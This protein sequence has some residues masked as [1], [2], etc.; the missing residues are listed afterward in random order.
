MSEE[1]EVSAEKV[2]TKADVVSELSDVEVHAMELGWKPKSEFK[3]DNKEFVSADEYL[4]RGPLIKEIMS[5]NKEIRE[6]K[7]TLK[8]LSDHM[9]NAEQAAYQRGMQAL[10]QK[11]EEAILSGDVE[12]VKALDKQKSDMRDQLNNGSPQD[13][14]TKEEKDF[15]DKHSTWFNDKPENREITEAAVFFDQYLLKTRTD[16]T[17]VDQLKL[18]EERVKKLYPDQFSNPKQSMPPSVAVSSGGKGSSRSSAVEKMTAQQRDIAEQFVR[19]IP[20]YTLE[21]YAKEL[22]KQGNLGK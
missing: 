18:V 6:M 15:I 16:L 12:T 11:R 10:E 13:K 20:G 8:K 21:R 4:R 5:R 3:D 9:S 7:D 2:E 19:T 17:R 1:K 14:L 22:D